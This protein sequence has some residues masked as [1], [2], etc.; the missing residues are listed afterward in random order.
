MRFTRFALKKNNFQTT[1][2]TKSTNGNR[3]SCVRCVS[4][5]KKT[6]IC[7]LHDSTNNNFVA[8]NGRERTHRTR[9][10]FSQ[11]LRSLRSFAADSGGD[12]A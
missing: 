9:K 4:W 11:S 12:S 5:L 2:R 8:S 3:L 10:K 6:A 7:E 1:E